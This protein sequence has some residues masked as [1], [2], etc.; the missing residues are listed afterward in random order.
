[1]FLHCRSFLRSQYKEGIR[2]ARDLLGK[3]PVEDLE[4][5][6]RSM[7]R[8][9]S[10]SEA[11]LIPVKGKKGKDELDSKSPRQQH[12]SEKARPMES[13]VKKDH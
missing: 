7:R 6:S 9:P 12:S 13:I 3:M 1:M 11:G 10:N 2:Y 8:E 4:K 5:G